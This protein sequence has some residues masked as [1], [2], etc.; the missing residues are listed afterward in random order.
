MSFP[1]KHNQ[2]G[3]NACIIHLSH[4]SVVWIGLAKGF[5]DDWIGSNNFSDPVIFESAISDFTIQTPD[6]RESED[7]LFLDV[8]VPEKILKSPDS[9]AP[10][11]VWIHGGGYA[12]GDKTSEGHPATFI[13]KSEV[14][15]ADGI[16]F[17]SINYRLGL[18]VS[19]SHFTAGLQLTSKGLALWERQCNCQRRPA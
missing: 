18:F 7:C 5:L 3:L 13:A 14:D 11:V 4:S 2:V 15:G 10:V 9:G 8:I 17:V 19:C 12:Y 16:V 6:P 1:H